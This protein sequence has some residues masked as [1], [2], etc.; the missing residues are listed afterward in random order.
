[1]F[2][3]SFELPESLTKQFAQD[4]KGE[5]IAL[6]LFGC[7]RESQKFLPLVHLSVILF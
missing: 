1:M 4:D 5:T 2:L 3:K 7:V 6:I